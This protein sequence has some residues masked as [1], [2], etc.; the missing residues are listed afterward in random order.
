MGDPI[1][2]RPL[3]AGI[4]WPA[5]PPVVASP[6]AVPPAPP[7]RTAPI[8]A[9]AIETLAAARVPP[10]PVIHVTID[11]ID[12]RAPATAPRAAP[13]NRSRSSMAPGVSLADYL[14]AG[15]RRRDGGAS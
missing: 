9:A 3:S 11:R 10:R 13:A 14:R 1:H 2:V 5:A 12:V 6:A 15:P 8:S 7:A 4:A